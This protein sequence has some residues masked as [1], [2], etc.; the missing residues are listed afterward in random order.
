MECFQINLILFGV[1]PATAI[2][3]RESKI[4]E[5][6]IYIHERTGY[7]NTF[8]LGSQ[9]PHIVIPG[10]DQRLQLVKPQMHVYTIK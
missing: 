5:F 7:I 2:D 8:L 4:K 3:H 10:Y 1:E 6:R 9:E